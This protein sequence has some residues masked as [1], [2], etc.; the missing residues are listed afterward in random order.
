MRRS[1]TTRPTASKAAEDGLGF[2]PLLP[3][4]CFLQPKTP[5]QQPHSLS[6]SSTTQPEM[7][8][9]RSQADYGHLPA[10]QTSRSPSAKVEPASIA[11]YQEWP[12]QG[13]LKRTRIGKETVYNLES[14]LPHT[15]EHLHIPVPSEALGVHTNETSTGAAKRKRVPWKLKENKTVLKMKERGCSWKEIH[16]ALPH[17]T[18]GAI[19][20]QYSTKL[21][22]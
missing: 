6:P 18:L 19:R 3:I 21:K 14:Q 8:E 5:S 9:A 7:D 12:F 4:V 1:R 20:V 13:L 11:E 17:W 2:R 22:K 10:P 16:N 15:P